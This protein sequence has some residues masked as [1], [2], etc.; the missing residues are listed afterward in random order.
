LGVW[1]LEQRYGEYGAD[2]QQCAADAQKYALN[3]KEKPA[4]AP[5]PK[6]EGHRG[7]LQKWQ[8]DT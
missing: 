5:R 4:P 7:G 3:V 2:S 6:K 1:D 8:F